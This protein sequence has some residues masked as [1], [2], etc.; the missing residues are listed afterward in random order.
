MSNTPRKIATTKSDFPLISGT[1][2][3]AI[4]DMMLY[5]PIGT[6]IK[7]MRGIVQHGIRDFTASI[8]E[9]G[10]KQPHVAGKA[11]AKSATRPAAPMGTI[12]QMNGVIEHQYCLVSIMLAP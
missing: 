7:A 10:A 3:S 4:P 8:D 11:K 9:F 2:I 5:I 12:E 6:V 1:L